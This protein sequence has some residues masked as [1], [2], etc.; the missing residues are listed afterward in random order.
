MKSAWGAF[1]ATAL[2]MWIGV[3]PASLPT[4]R[5][6]SS[7]SAKCNAVG[8]ISL[9]DRIAGCTAVIET[10]AATQ[11]SVIFAH[12][13]RAGFYLQK[14]EVDRAIADY[15]QIIEHDPN[16][17]GARLGRASAYVRKR[18]F[19][20]AL[21]DY[22]KAIELDPKDVYAYQGRAGARLVKGDIDGAIAD[23]GRVVLIHPDNVSAYV[24]RGLAYNAKD[25]PD[26]AMADC[27]RA[28]E[29]SPEHGSGQ[30]CRGVA[31]YKKGDLDRAIAEYT[32]AIQLAPKYKDAYYRRAYAYKAK[33]DFNRAIADYDQVI[34]L[35]PKNAKAY[36]GRGMANFYAGS[37]AKSLD[38]LNQS[39]ALD[40]QDGYTALWLDIVGKR[41]NQ[42]SRLAEA[43]T[44]LDMTKWPA[45]VIRLFLGQLTPEAILAAADDPDAKKKKGQFCE[46]SFYTGELI[47][48]QGRK[49]DAVR[50]IRSAAADCPMTFIEWSAANAELRAFGANP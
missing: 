5:A 20:A 14:A 30:F 16:N 26:R 41:N 49:D 17:L 46:A 40:A 34:Q 33:G 23:Y 7:L 29:I 32:Q 45:P 44:Q 47:L 27:N 2:M 38:D 3:L 12:S 1:T 25:E 9:D 42:P 24:G 39:S 15:D 21:A 43:T 31:Y 22:E 13:R 8:N 48:Q 18:E 4:A 28:I 35:D 10:T 36:R 37:L 11:Q 19:D 50:L 6:Q